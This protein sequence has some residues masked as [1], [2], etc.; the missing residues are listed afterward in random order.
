MQCT[1]WI[2]LVLTTK[3][4]CFLFVSFPFFLFPQISQDRPKTFQWLLP[5]LLMLTST[6]AHHHTLKMEA[7]IIWLHLNLVKLHKQIHKA[8]LQHTYT[9]GKA[10]FAVQQ[11][12]FKK[13]CSY[14]F[15]SW[16]CLKIINIYGE[17]LAISIIQKAQSPG[18]KVQGA[19]W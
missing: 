15:L 8:G 5:C 7:I 13:K 14:C 17:G 11:T 2:Q 18:S 10:L 4:C 1:D 3:C 12:C 6:I 19:V 16:V 9:Y